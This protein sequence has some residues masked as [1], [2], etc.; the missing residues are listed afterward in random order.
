MFHI[1]EH[2]KLKY[3]QRRKALQKDKKGTGERAVTEDLKFNLFSLIIE[4]G[5]PRYGLDK[6]FGLGRS[7]LY[8]HFF[9]KKSVRNRE[10]MSL[11]LVLIDFGVGLDIQ[12]ALELQDNLL[13][14]CG[15]TMPK[16]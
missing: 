6:M 13:Q 5:D 15:Q 3:F 14:F 11:L 4:L 8:D 9:T 12:E 16:K 7:G 10:S 2:I 1:I